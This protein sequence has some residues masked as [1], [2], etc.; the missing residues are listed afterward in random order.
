[1]LNSKSLQGIAVLICGAFL[2]IWLGLS[3]VT[4][5]TETILQ[6]IAAA[7]FII[8]LALGTKIWLL[9]PFMAA[10][11][12]GLRMPGQPDS[13]LLGQILFIG[14]SIPQLLLR[15][16]H[17]RL[18]LTELEFWIIMLTLIIVQVYMRNPVGINLFGGDVVGGK[19]YIIFAIGLTTSFLLVGLKVPPSELKWILRLSILGGLMNQ[20]NS[21]LGRIFPTFGFYTGQNYAKA[22]E[23]NYENYGKA[24]DDRAA[25]RDGTLSLFGS[26]LSLWICSFKSPLKAILHPLWGTLVLLSL[27]AAT[28][29]GYRNGVAMMFFTYFVGVC[30][31]GGLASIILS[32]IGGILAIALLAM[33]NSTSPLP[34]N[35]QRSLSFLP[36]TWE[37]RYVQDAEDSSEWRFE[38]WKEVLT[39]NRWIQN[40]WLG[41]G[42]GFTARE[43]QYALAQKAAQSTAKG[44]S[45]FD[46][47][48]ETML[49]NGNYHSGPVQTIRVIGYIGLA[50][51]LLFQIR[52]AIHAH[53]QIKRC[54]GTEWFPLALLIGI[55]LIWNPVFFVF[56]FGE[57]KT[58]AA[59]LL[60][61]TSMIRLL[62][63]NLPLPAYAKRRLLPLMQQSGHHASL[64]EHRMARA[65]Q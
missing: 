64:T 11:S 55:P 51:I 9:I 22:D 53:R 63:N 60:L 21:I 6:I 42:L 2:S 16:L 32:F 58:A 40:K 56:I 46:A 36:G 65:K 52:L 17:L 10:L 8:C 62:Q 13:L 33:I 48:R 23:V 30:Y 43:Y 59:T 34:P 24:V 20:M 18:A 19:P 44:M 27:A 29:S 41:D 3:I 26:N 57:F 25:T 12:V 47:Q 35:I 14:F 61:G 7:I 38:M 39:T 31:R 28:L 5:Q 54:R 15:K 37:K 4:N 49:S 1:M 50:I 45:G